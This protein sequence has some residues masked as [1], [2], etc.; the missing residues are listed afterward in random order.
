MAMVILRSIIEASPVNNPILQT[1]LTKDLKQKTAL[2]VKD[3]LR[4]KAH[5]DF[6]IGSLLIVR[7]NDFPLMKFQF[8]VQAGR[9]A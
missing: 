4:I 3:K 2:K 6:E 1:Q 7:M 5:D 8:I 9:L